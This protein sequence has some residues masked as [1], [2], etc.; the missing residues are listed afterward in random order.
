MATVPRA[1]HLARPFDADPAPVRARTPRMLVGVQGILSPC[2]SPAAPSTAS[3]RSPTSS[4]AART[5]PSRWRRWPGAT[6]CRRS[7]SSRSWRRSSTAASSGRRSA[8]AAATRWPTTRRRSRSGRVIRLLDGA[9]APLTCVSLRYYA[10]CSCPDEATCSLRDVML[11]VRDAMLAI[12]DEQTLADLAARPGRASIDPARH[13]RG[14]P[15]GTASLSRRCRPADNASRPGRGR[16]LPADRGIESASP[17]PR[18]EPPPDDRL[19]PSA[20]DAFAAFVGFGRGIWLFPLDTMF[21]TVGLRY[22]WLKALFTAAP[23]P[24]IRGIGRLR[25]ERAAWRAS[26]RVPAYG[27]YLEESGVDVAGAVPARDPAPPAGDRQE[28][29]RRPLRPARALRR[30]G[31]PLPGHDDRRIERLDGDAVQLDPRPQGTRGRASQHRVLRPLRVRDRAARDDQRVLDGR[32]G[33]RDEHEHGDDAPR[34]RQ[35]GRPRRR[36]DPLDARATSARRT[37][38]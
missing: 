27:R 7:S 35:V 28:V 22:G 23:P 37:A 6:T 38:S 16:V 21:R 12:L 4:A 24:L 2:A 34:H 19:R 1:V 30:R 10:T 20:R 9:L 31:G 14:G 17:P 29:V 8:R 18:E 25:A 36:Q 33:R 15:R 5:R 3:A 32:V 26:R 11:D 13:P